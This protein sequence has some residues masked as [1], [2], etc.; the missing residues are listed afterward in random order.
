M[1]R[2]VPSSGL[3]HLNFLRSRR[4][5]RSL[6]SLWSLT[7]ASDNVEEVENEEDHQDGA[8]TAAGTVTPGAA[9]GPGRH[10]A[11]HAEDENNEEN[12]DHTLESDRHR[13]VDAGVATFPA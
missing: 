9:V 6:W 12:G 7:A 2:G 11:D 4:C 3:E 13:A 10:R 5:F 8:E 1:G